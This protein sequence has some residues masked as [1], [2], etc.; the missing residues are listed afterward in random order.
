MQALAQVRSEAV[1]WAGL[2]ICV[3]AAVTASFAYWRW[4]RHRLKVRLDERRRGAERI[5]ELR[6]MTGGLAHEIK[7]P[8]S[9]LVLNAQLLRED[10]L[11]LDL[12]EE[13]RSRIG[14]RV[15]ALA[16]EAARLR[17]ILEDF[18]RYAGRI[19]LD[20]QARDLREVVDELVDFFRPQAVQSGV[21]LRLATPDDPVQVMVDAGL[22]KQAL[23]N[24]MINAVQ[25][26]AHSERRELLIRVERDRLGPA[27]EAR[28]HVIDTGPG[29]PEEQRAT[30]FLPYSSSRPGGT[31]L[32]L[33][34]TR[35][36]MEEHGGRVTLFTDP[37]VGSD[38]VL[39]LPLSA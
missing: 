32:G 25:A 15:D 16:R 6:S 8:L 36:I 20:R 9:T 18:L 3:G 31:G 30:L 10:V 24:L 5:S 26:M 23:L 27:P 28:V 11:D 22:F 4:R 1:L 35:R 19:Q 38:F 33:A 12:P 37:G 17:Q 34:T 13:S 39:H 29:I 2:W 7:N 14:R 21:V